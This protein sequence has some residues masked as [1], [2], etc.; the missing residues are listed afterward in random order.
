MTTTIHGIGSGCFS[1]DSNWV[2]SDF[3]FTTSKEGLF[4]YKEEKKK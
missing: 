3:A 1:I 4:I 2:N